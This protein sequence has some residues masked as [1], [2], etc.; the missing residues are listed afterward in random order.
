ML[1]S[2]V[3]QI[4]ISQTAGGRYIPIGMRGGET[5]SKSETARLSHSLIGLPG[6]EQRHLANK[7]AHQATGQQMKHK[8]GVRYA[9][10]I[11]VIQVD[12]RVGKGTNDDPVR[13]I[14]E[15]WSLDGQLLARVDK[16][17]LPE[18]DNDEK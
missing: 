9:N 3:L 1:E 17:E 12:S 5:Q 4:P 15:Y 18:I 8:S 16:Y 10:V 11:Q 2:R 14:T 13:V 7:S 6:K